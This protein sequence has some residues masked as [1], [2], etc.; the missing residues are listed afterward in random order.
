MEVA[1]S[2]NWFIDMSEA[3]IFSSAISAAVQNLLLY[4]LINK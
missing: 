2:I 3:A 4:T 1:T